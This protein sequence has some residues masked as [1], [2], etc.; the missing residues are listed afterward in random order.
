MITQTEASQAV[1]T[2][3]RQIHIFIK[4]RTT[5]ESQTITRIRLQLCEFQMNHCSSSC[6]LIPGLTPQSMYFR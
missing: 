4:E 5:L 2:I 1:K 6:K 3:I